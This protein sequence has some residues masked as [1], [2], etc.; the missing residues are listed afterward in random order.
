MK[1]G[2]IRLSREVSQENSKFNNSKY[3]TQFPFPT[4]KKLEN[5]KLYSHKKSTRV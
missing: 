3:A 2:W 4:L 1:T 5:E